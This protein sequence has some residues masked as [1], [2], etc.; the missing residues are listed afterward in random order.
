[1]KRKLLSGEFDHTLDP[2]GRV[3]L[4]ARYRDYFSDGV[5]LVR[6]RDNEP[7]VRVYHPDAWDEFDEK[8]LEP[9][10]VFENQGDSWRT[11]SIY[12]NQ[13]RVEVDRQG[14]VLLPSKRIEELGLSGKLKIIGNRTHLEIWDP[15]TLEAM[16]QEGGGG[17]A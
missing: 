5:V 4:P 12:R 16:E 11:R 8:F 17:N 2:K 9:L 13:D 15:A 10:N 14:R 7:C 1:M 3:T 6:F